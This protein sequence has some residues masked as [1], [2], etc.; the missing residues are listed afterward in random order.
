MITS[1]I[2][3]LASVFGFAAKIVSSITKD[4]GKNVVTVNVINKEY[5]Q[6]IISQTNEHFTK[7]LKESENRIIEEIQS[8]D[9][10]NAIQQVQAHTQS[11]K[12]LLNITNTDFETLQKIVITAL[13]P[14]QVSLEVAKLKLSEYDKI[15]YWNYCYMLGGSALLAGYT[16]LGLEMPALREEL[17]KEIKY[18]QL[19][20][21][22]ETALIILSE[23]EDFPWE[24]VPILLSFEGSEELSELYLNAL[25]KKQ[26]KDKTANNSKTKESFCSDCGKNNA[27]F[28][29]YDNIYCP[30]CKKV[31]GQ[32]SAL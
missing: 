18:I 2:P 4:E 15:E 16:F 30:N 21:L 10:R 20:I 14:L 24:R 19:K 32:K 17:E 25:P 6:A 26:N 23:H 1:F 9:I 27:Y 3:L 31:I 7:L 8:R 12:Y 13:N 28:D 5:L 11:L 29:I 22:R